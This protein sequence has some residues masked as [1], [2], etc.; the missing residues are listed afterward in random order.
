MGVLSFCSLHKH[1]FQ[2]RHLV[3]LF[4]SKCLAG[5]SASSMLGHPPLFG[6]DRNESILIFRGKNG[7]ICPNNLKTFQNDNTAFLNV[8]MRI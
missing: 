6:C 4:L 2:V 7:P 3:N 8:S 1:G 5:S